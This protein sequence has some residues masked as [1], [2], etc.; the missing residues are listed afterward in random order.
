MCERVLR[1]VSA[2]IG[3]C[4]VLA[5]CTQARPGP[6]VADPAPSVI[7]IADGRKGWE[8]SDVSAWRES[9]PV[10][11]A[12]DSARAHWSTQESPHPE[13]VDV[14]ATAVGSFTR[15]GAEQ[16]VVLYRMSLYP[17]GFPR[18][19]LAL[20]EGDALVRNFA[21]SG[22]AHDLG[23]LPDID[24]DGRDELLFFSSFAMGGQQTWGVGIARFSDT[25]LE[26][27]GHATL[28]ED[29]CGMDPERSGAPNAWRLFS[30][31]GEGMRT[32]RYGR[33][34]CEAETWRPVGDP[35]PFASESEQRYDAVSLR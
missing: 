30:A 25:G 15:A 24:G 21:F 26:H 34:S 31:P 20:I 9:P 11:G 17:R 1:R 3:V 18:K 33:E 16:R 13:D 19:G 2:G 5:G 6:A 12:I 14:Q 10:L 8:E 29:A 7:E 28:Y 27:L 23:T 32:Q 22:L 4:A 35:E